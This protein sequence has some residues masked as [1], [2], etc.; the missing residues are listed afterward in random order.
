VSIY[1]SD[2]TVSLHLGKALDVL[3]QIPDASI[4]AV[5]CDPPYALTNLHPN[6]VIDALTRW[7]GGDHAYVPSGRGGFMNASW[8]EFV[9]PPAAWD[10][11]LRVLK[12]GGHLLAFAAPRTQ[13]LMGMSIRIAG[14]EIRDSIDWIFGCLTDDAEVLTED[15]WK[16]G[17]DIQAG[18]SVAQWDHA[19]GQ[20]TLAAVEQTYRA[21]WNGPM[22]VLRNADTDQLLTP[23]H[24]VYHRARQRRMV[25]GRRKIWF[26]ETWQVAQA[27]SLSTWNAL[28]LP[29]AGEHNG[30]GIGGDDYAALLGWVWTEGGFD[31]EGTGVRIYQSSVNADKVTEIAALMDRI[32]THKRY[33]R[34]RTYKVR[35]YTETMWYFSGELA[36]RVRADLP[37]K[38]PSYSLLWRMT[39]SEKR[40]FLRT[41]MLGDG[42]GLNS[43]CEIFYQRYESDLVWLQTL[44]ALIGRAGKVGMRRNRP[45]GQLS[46]RQHGTT[47]LQARH[48]RNDSEAY[49][50]E[51]WCVKV[52]N[53]AFL[54]RR[55]G[56]VF[57][58][59]NSGFPKG[60]DI[61]KSVDRRRDDR[62]DVLAVTAW[63][64]NAR[65]A[66]GWS[67]RQI[68]ALWGFDGMAGHW[69]T[70]GK[71]ATVPTPEQWTALRDALSFDDADILPLVNQL[72][73]R[74]GLL[75]ESWAKREVVGEGYRVRRH[76]D[77]QIAGV[78]S[79]RYD[80]TEPASEA[81]QQWQGWNTAL[82]P[83]HEPI[84]VARKT[85]GFNTT[86][87]NVLK[88]GTGA[89][90]VDA[91]RIEAGQDYREKCASVVGLASNR[92]GATLGEWTGVRE[93]SAHPAGRW[94][95]NLLLTHSPDCAEQ[96]A[97]DCPVADVNQQSGITASSGGTRGGRIGA[98]GVLGKFEHNGPRANAGG[99]GD[100]G[101]ASRFF[102]AFRYESKAPASE[103]PRLDDGTVHTTVKP[104]DLMRWLVRLVC[105]PGGTI[106]DPFVGSGTTLE[107]CVVEGFRGIGIEQHQPYAD[108][109]VK[110]LSKPIQAV[111]GF[112]EE[113]S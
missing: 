56:M 47:E 24:R 73:A 50:G 48:L 106:L 41:A 58:T 28:Q 46:L 2:D 111:L 102:P 89:I 60:Q 53:G 88:H 3:P 64:A 77:V 103:R 4:D 12:P 33:D 17:I 92:N 5:V 63:L 8:D 40:A 15:G 9:P 32:G 43:S 21:P 81:A 59:G 95:T 78:S 38:R 7:L 25:N 13:D 108:L 72:N 52:P 107:A 55:N 54:A 97:N 105:P 65:D 79:G 91:C 80:L 11:C 101:G 66:A 57:I 69:T 96:C 93:D 100:S 67:N 18:E 110:R 90:N 26:D 75:G 70:Q 45:G 99:L 104:L 20:I 109:C 34:N 44:L 30:P 19:T 49:A 62:A 42:S 85:T 10:E 76:S 86:V 39:G 14:F 6:V 36:K 71:A 112:E 68:D 61:S 35:T 87:A 16:R 94:P 83:A 82:K 74:K 37:R 1:Y 31:P 51:V 84:V 22:R 29:L 27:G 98:N 113:A 23:N